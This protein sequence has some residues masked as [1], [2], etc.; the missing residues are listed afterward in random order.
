[1]KAIIETHVQAG[2]KR[3]SKQRNSSEIIRKGS[4][5]D[6]QTAAR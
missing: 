6:E 5:Y 4:K 3:V 1:M 2:V